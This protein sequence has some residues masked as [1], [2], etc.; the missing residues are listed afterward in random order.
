MRDA[1]AR[2]EKAQNGAFLVYR[3]G[4]SRTEAMDRSEGNDAGVFARGR[5]FFCGLC[6]RALGIRRLL[7]L[8]TSRNYGKHYILYKNILSKIAVITVY[9]QFLML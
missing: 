3:A 6:L 4:R 5:W 8:G 9:A 7:S 2:I 1:G